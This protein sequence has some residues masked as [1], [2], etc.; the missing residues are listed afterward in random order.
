MKYLLLVVFAAILSPFVLAQQPPADPTISAFEING[1]K[2]IFKRRTTSPTIAAGMFVRGGVRNATSSTSGL[3]NLT[4]S[5]AMEGS[6]TYPV[7]ALRKEMAR[8]GSSVGAAAGI[9]FGVMSLSST[10]E[11]FLRSWAVFTDLINNPEFSNESI[12]RTRNGILAGLR[13]R[14]SSPDSA[15]D[16][17]EEKVV[18]AGHPYSSDP[19]G[20]IES[21]SKF[22]PADL[23]AYHRSILETSRLLLVIVGDSDEK[24][25]RQLVTS[26]FGGMS[27]GN[28][29]EMPL[30][31]LTF[32]A[33]SLDVSSRTLSTN[34]IKGI[35]QAPSLS[36]P[37]YYAMRV[38]I[39][40]L[41]SRV[42]QEVRIARNLSYAPNAE[43]GER[44]AN[45]A[46][47]YVTAVDANQSVRVML[48]EIS[49]MRKAVIEP[50][51]FEGVSGYF[52]TMHYLDQETNA[53]QANEL[54]RYELIGGGWQNS[55]KF[56]TGIM[57]VT[58]EAVW[59]ASIKYMKN[60][61]F[62]VVGDPAAID[63]S[64]FVP[65]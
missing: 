60:I 25:I 37:D 40:I 55:T 19:T 12:E 46:N 34:Y 38:A 42:Y 54:A 1:L 44:A 50:D 45:S 23:R 65:N 13:D 4:L 27:R 8:T 56:I 10:T 29:K 57:N 11:N 6:K 3:E 51:E 64:I 24:T 30:P 48:N 17:L 16:S 52:L 62:V 58:P 61:R 7:A 22:T 59:E 49:K 35:F 32:D 28:Y 20:T 63:R 18:Y 41:Q 43:M 15:L 2:V 47:I 39:A 36:D 5:A 14:N 26:S 53:A 9:D 31:R 33:P 21:V